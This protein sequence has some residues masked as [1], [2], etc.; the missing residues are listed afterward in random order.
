MWWCNAASKTSIPFCSFKDGR[1]AISNVNKRISEHFGTAPTPCSQQQQ[2][3]PS[4]TLRRNPSSKLKSDWMKS[5]ASW[6]SRGHHIL[7]IV[8]TYSTHQDVGTV[9]IA[10]SQNA[11]Q[12][13]SV[14]QCC[15]SADWPSALSISQEIE[16]LDV[17]GQVRFHPT[18]HVPHPKCRAFA[19]F[20]LSLLAR[21]SSRI[22]RESR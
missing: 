1:V 22:K 18:L 13:I 8:R 16:T 14:F 3:H 19:S 9:G 17:D 12:Y 6:R 7:V 11:V 10:G 20:L 4:S 2:Q 15:C 5:L 21:F